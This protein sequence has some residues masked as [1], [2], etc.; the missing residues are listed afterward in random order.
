MKQLSISK[1]HLRQVWYDLIDASLNYGID[2]HPQ[3]DMRRLGIDIIA[4][5]PESIADG[6]NFLTDYQGELPG[7]ITEV[8]LKSRKDYWELMCDIRIFD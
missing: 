6:W 7:Y 4:S 8:D 1:N 5:V 3:L 2:I